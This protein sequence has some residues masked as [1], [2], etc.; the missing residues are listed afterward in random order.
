M[1]LEAS[2]PSPHY[3]NLDQFLYICDCGGSAE[4]TITH[5]N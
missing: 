2:A 4:K 3:V 5:P 1:R